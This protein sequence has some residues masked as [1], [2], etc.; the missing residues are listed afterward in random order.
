M[1][2]SLTP[3]QIHHIRLALLARRKALLDEVTE[4]LASLDHPRYADVAQE[5]HDRGDEAVADVLSEINLGVKDLHINEI[6]EIE[7]TIDRIE[8]R[9]FGTCVACGDAIESQ[10]LLAFPTA[11]RCLECQRRYEASRQ[12]KIAKL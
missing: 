11:K 1:N 2:T 4:E 12:Q 10:R 6:I 9:E 8:R 3:E 7:A 5:V